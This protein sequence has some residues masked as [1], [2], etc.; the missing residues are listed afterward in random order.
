M[1]LTISCSCLHLSNTPQLC[2]N[3]QFSQKKSWRALFLIIDILIRIHTILR[4]KNIND[5]LLKRQCLFHYDI[6]ANMYIHQRHLNFLLLHTMTIK[7]F[8]KY[9]LNSN[10]MYFWKLF[11]NKTDEIMV[12]SKYSWTVTSSCF[13][14]RPETK[15]CEWL[16]WALF[17]VL[18][19]P[20]A[21]VRLLSTKTSG[22]LVI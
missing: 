18:I 12:S 10:S 9:W 6:F 20:R 2:P 1:Q 5:R 4:S 11:F 19:K 3:C 16:A 7:P 15:F 22:D 17:N 8:K 14:T 13:S 21:Y